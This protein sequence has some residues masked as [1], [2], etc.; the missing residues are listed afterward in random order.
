MTH[1]THGGKEAKASGKGAFVLPRTVIEIQPDFVLGARLNMRPIGVRRMA[2]RALDPG[3]IEPS[4]VQANV[5]KPEPLRRA[6]HGMRAS[7]Q[8]GGQAGLLVPDGAVRVSILGFETLPAKS[9][10]LDPLIRWR[11][12]DTLGYAP[13]SA[14]LSWQLNWSEPGLT[15][16]LVVAMKADVLDQFG[17][18]LAPLGTPVLILP[19]TMAV[20][21]LCPAASPDAQLLTHVCSGWV[22]HVAVEGERMRLWRSRRLSHPA[23]NAVISEVISEAARAAASARDRMGIEIKAAWFC[24]RP[25][26]GD[27][28][29]ELSLALGMPVQALP[30]GSNLD[31]LLQVEEKP[32]FAPFAAPVAGLMVNSAA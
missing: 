23:P 18:A 2:L 9:E 5:I 3:V 4:P 29:G 8:N 27:L 13:E 12:K 19:A 17:A 15:E 1:T 16:L 31:A 30:I 24:A 26:M 20:M 21:A 11:L 32:L 10:D 22:T 28:G 6:L 7:V 14:R 25:A